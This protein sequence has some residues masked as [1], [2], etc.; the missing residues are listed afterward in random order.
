[1]MS[2]SRSLFLCAAVV[3]ICSLIWFARRDLVTAIIFLLIATVELV[4][5]IIFWRKSKNSN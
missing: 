1:M 5:G 2:K 4:A 3:F